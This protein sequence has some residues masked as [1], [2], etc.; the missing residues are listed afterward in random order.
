MFSERLTEAE[1]RISTAEDKITS[2]AKQAD[3][4]WERVNKLSSRLEEME[5]LQ[6]RSNL[7]LVGLPEGAEMRVHS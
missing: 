2:Q 5:N 1:T 6:R 7:R 4:T 3:T